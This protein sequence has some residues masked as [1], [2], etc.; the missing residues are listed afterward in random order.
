MYKPRYLKRGVLLRHLHAVHYQKTTKNP[1]NKQQKNPTKPKTKPKPQNL[2]STK[3]YCS[4]R[5][6]GPNL[7]FRKGTESTEYL[8]SPSL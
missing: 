4:G 8:L 2:Y 3:H 5:K 1:P 7:L 6:S